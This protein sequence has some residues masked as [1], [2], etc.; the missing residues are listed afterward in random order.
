MSIEEVRNIFE[1]CMK[2][3]GLEKRTHEI[4]PDNP[5]VFFK[6]SGQVAWLEVTIYPTGWASDAPSAG[7][8]FNLDEPLDLGYYAAFVGYMD[9]FAECTEN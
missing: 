8:R 9:R 7:F 6:L 4:T 1:I 3:Q 2:V 5:T